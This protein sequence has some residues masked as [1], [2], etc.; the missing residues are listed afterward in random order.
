M[1]LQ[2]P[3]FKIFYDK[4]AA[5]YL[6]KLQNIPQTKAQNGVKIG[7]NSQKSPQFFTSL[8]TQRP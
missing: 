4:N 2:P 1:P 8:L 6:K 7:Q 5:K 3:A